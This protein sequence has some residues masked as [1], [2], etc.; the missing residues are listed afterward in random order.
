MQVCC[1]FIFKDHLYN[2]YTNLKIEERS[3][4]QTE[5]QIQISELTAPDRPRVENEASN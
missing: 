1:I 2:A 3:S 4:Q 5:I